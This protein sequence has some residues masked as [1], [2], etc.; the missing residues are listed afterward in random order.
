M[1][2]THPDLSELHGKDL[3]LCQ[4]DIEFVETRA[5]WD[6]HPPLLALSSLCNHLAS[7][8]ILETKNIEDRSIQQGPQD[9]FC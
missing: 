6:L 5:F 1:T 4:Q 8:S 3:L 7:S 9:W 2:Q